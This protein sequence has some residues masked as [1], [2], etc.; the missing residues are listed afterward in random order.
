MAATKQEPMFHQTRLLTPEIQ[1][2]VCEAIKHG[3]TLE[4]AARA[5]GIGARTLDEWLKHGR[6]EL[7]ADPDASGPCAIFVSEVMIAAAKSEQELI[8]IIRKEAP[9]TWQ[10]AAWLLERKFPQRYAKVDRLRVSGDETNERPITIENRQEIENKLLQ[11]LADFAGKALDKLE[12]DDLPVI[13]GEVIE[14]DST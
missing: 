4:I 11:K 6:D 14:V 7:Q 2:T 5:A 8:E 13:D 9:K 10:A 12:K 3:A 1:K